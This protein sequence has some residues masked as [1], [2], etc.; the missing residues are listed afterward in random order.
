MLE[1]LTKLSVLDGKT[2]KCLGAQSFPETELEI[3]SPEVGF[4]E[5]DPEVWWDCIKRGAVANPTTRLV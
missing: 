4:A 3:S 1:A 2:G 5:Q